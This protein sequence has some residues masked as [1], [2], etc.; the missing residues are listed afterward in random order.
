M[1]QYIT[2][3]DLDYSG[4]DLFGLDDDDLDELLSG[5]DIVGDDIVGDAPKLSLAKLK[6]AKK[7]AMQ[8]KIAANFQRRQM[9]GR[10]VEYKP[11]KARVVREY[12][13]GFDSLVTIAPGATLELTRRPQ[14]PFRVDRLVVP[15][16]IAGFFQIGDFKVG[17]NSQFAAS[18]GVPARVFA[19]NAVGVSLGLDTASI[20]QDLVITVTN[21]SA[22]P[23]RFTCATIGTAVE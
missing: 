20:S 12:V 18:G 16:D 21:Q 15:S 1:S 2:G 6:A 19:E 22:A 10:A 23:Q 13:L 7:A 3:E 8:R 14:V 9:P 4:A 17:K 11:F 5:D